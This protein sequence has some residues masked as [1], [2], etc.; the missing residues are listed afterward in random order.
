MA[1]LKD[2]VATAAVAEPMTTR[3]ADRDG[4]V[5]TLEQPSCDHQLQLGWHH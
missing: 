1:E 5:A 4:E 2:T 3:I